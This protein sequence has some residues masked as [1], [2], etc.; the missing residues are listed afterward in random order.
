MIDKKGKD[1]EQN[2]MELK[3]VALDGA[4]KGEKYVAVTVVSL[5]APLGTTTVEPN[6]ISHNGHDANKVGEI[7]QVDQTMMGNVELV[8]VQK[9]FLATKENEFE[10]QGKDVES[11]KIRWESRC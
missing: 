7:S 8:E 9:E 3:L 6:Q 11:K 5:V 1:L 2:L 4:N 10:L